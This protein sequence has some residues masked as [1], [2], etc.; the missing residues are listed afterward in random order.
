MAILCKLSEL[1][2]YIN[3]TQELKL[4][5]ASLTNKKIKQPQ[6]ININNRDIYASENIIETQPRDTK[7]YESHKK[8]IDIH[9]VLTGEEII[10]VAPIDALNPSTLYDREKDYILYKNKAGEMYHLKPGICAIFFPQ[11]AHMPGIAANKPEKISK[12]VIKVLKN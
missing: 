4:Y 6:E 8:Y 9:I 7:S 1:G 12:I 5:L 3:L 10:E 2:K 11:D